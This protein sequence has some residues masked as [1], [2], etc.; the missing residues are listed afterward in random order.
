MLILDCLA[1][2][3]HNAFP[4][5]ESKTAIGFREQSEFVCK[6]HDQRGF[7]ATCSLASHWAAT[8]TCKTGG[9]LEGNF[10]SK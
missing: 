9:K 8:K 2:T 1:S 4:K 3:F 5:D 7:L 10:Y 6:E